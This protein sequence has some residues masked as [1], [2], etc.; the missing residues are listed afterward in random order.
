M[1]AQAAPIKIFQES[2]RGGVA[3][4]GTGV[5]TPRLDGSVAANAAPATPND[6][7]VAWRPIELRVPARATIRKA[8]LAVLSR[9]PTPEEAER[10]RS[11]VLLVDDHPTNRQVI[12]RQLALAGYA[13]ETADDGLEGLER[14]R[15]GRYAL[16]RAEN[17]ETNPQQQLVDLEAVGE[18]P[19]FRR[20]LLIDTHH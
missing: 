3:T 1:I 19:R 9:L 10:E 17:P 14:W 13:S 8:Y 18:R 5:A 20:V 15:S 6:F 7:T 4:D 11:L 2:I 16:L 12:Q